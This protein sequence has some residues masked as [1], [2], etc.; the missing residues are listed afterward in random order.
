MFQFDLFEFDIDKGT[1]K[2][3][4]AHRIFT[5]KFK[6]NIVTTAIPVFIIF[7]VLQIFNFVL[8]LLTMSLTSKDL[9]LKF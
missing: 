2:F 5:I 9:N 6:L 7:T 8:L 4:F 1:K 3:L